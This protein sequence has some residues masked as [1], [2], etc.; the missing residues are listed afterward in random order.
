MQQQKTHR[1]ACAAEFNFLTITVATAV[2]IPT[3]STR[4]TLPTMVN[5]TKSIGF[6]MSLHVLAYNMKRMM[7]IVGT[8]PL[9]EAIRASEAV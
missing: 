5:P 4:V 3:P 1:H 2:Q 9:I 7:N 6:K 8:K